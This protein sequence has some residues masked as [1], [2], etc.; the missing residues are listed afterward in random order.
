M[1]NGFVPRREHF[2]AVGSRTSPK[3][4]EEQS[5]FSWISPFD[6]ST[7]PLHPACIFSRS[8]PHSPLNPNPTVRA[9]ANHIRSR[10][11]YERPEGAWFLARKAFAVILNHCANPSC[12]GARERRVGDD[13]ALG[14]AQLPSPLRHLGDAC[15]C[16]KETGGRERPPPSGKRGGGIRLQFGAGARKGWGDSETHISRSQDADCICS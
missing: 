6:G 3:R 4:G 10:A 1:V 7:S 11:E 13:T 2:W 5:H 15:S 16:A 8:S 9:E 12:L 14:T